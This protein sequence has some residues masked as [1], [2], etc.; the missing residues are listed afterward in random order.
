MEEPLETAWVGM[1]AGCSTASRSHWDRVNGVSQG[2]G[3]SDMAP[4]KGSVG[5]G[6]RKEQGPLPALPSG[7]KLPLQCLP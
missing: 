1:Q 7:R 2:D 5:Q 3:V 6:L 4:P